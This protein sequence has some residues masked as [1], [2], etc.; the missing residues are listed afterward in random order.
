MRRLI[1]TLR[2]WRDSRRH[3]PSPYTLR[4]AWG[5]AGRWA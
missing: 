5:V 3:M 1:L 4:R 2:I